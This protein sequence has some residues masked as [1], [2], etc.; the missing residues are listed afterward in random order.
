[1]F[2]LLLYLLVNKFILDDY[3]PDIYVLPDMTIITFFAYLENSTKPIF[4]FA[5]I[6]LSFYKC[7]L[8]MDSK[9]NIGRFGCLYISLNV[10]TISIT[11]IYKVH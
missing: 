9:L 8:V 4:L 1:M 5:M 11:I 10:C 7:I 2:L 6:F 3:L